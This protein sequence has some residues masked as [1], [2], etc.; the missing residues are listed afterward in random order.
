MQQAEIGHFAVT[1]NNKTFNLIPSLRNMAKLANATR[2]LTFY[3][4]IHSSKVPDWIRLD[5]ARDILLA[6]SNDA[7]IDKHLIKSR[8]QKPHLNKDK[9][10]INDQVVVAASLMRH[11]IAGVNRPDYSGNKGKS[12]PLDKFDVNKIVADAM[13][14]FGLSRSEAL[15]L[16]MSEFCQL[17]AAKFPPESSK[18]DTPS[19]DDHKAAMKALMEKNNGK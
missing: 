3:E 15:D 4:M 11:G 17:L 8:R 19:L 9:I 2:I 16:T 10:S 6:C 14:H 5:L 13:I 1:I 18:Q 7:A 12:K